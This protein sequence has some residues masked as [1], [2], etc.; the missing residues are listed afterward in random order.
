MTSSTK[1]RTLMAA[2]IVPAALG[3]ATTA[4]ASPTDQRSHV[5]ALYATATP[6]S[7][8][9]FRLHEERDRLVRVA[10]VTSQLASAETAAHRLEKLITT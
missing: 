1:H 8:A 2:L 6:G 4:Q 3:I 7:A 9:Q 5:D 10:V